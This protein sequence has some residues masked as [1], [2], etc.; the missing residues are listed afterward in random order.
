M[1]SVW[2]QKFVKDEDLCLVEYK[3]FR[4][5]TDIELP[6]VSLC[7][8]HPFL[9]EKLKDLGTN[10]SEYV[11]HLAGDDINQNM[12][13]INYTDVTFN[14]DKFYSKSTAMH[15]GKFFDNIGSEIRTRSNM[16]RYGT[17]TKCYG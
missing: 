9:D 2:V 15:D 10:T 11:K 4:S 5:T 7:I 17:F 3:S 13:N 12:A 8:E 14:L 1:V 6:D 16:F